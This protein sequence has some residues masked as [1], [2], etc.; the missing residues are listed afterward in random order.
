MGLD[1][2]ISFAEFLRN[3]AAKDNKPMN[4]TAQV[5]CDHADLFINLKKQG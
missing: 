4:T 1:S 3:S 5:F 2:V